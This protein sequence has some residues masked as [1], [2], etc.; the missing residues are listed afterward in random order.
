[1]GGHSDPKERLFTP[2]TSKMLNEAQLAPSPLL[3]LLMLLLLLSLS[4]LSCSRADPRPQF[5]CL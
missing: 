3:L 2:G 4:S 5:S 1:M